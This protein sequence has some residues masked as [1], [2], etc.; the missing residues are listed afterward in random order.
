MRG[1]AL[2]LGAAFLG[3]TILAA[4]PGPVL[5]LAAGDFAPN[6]ASPAAPSWF[7]ATPTWE[8]PRGSRYLVAIMRGPLGGKER[9]QLEATGVSILGYVPVHG[10]QLRVPPVSEAAARRLPFVAW[11]GPLPPHLKLAP[12]LSASSPAAAADARVRIILAAGEPSARVTALLGTMPS[13]ATPSGKDGAYRVVATIPGKSLATTLS[14]IASLPEVEAIEPARRF[15]PMNQDAVW[16]HQ[17]FVGPSPQTTPI[18]ARGIF[19]CGQIAAIADT[20]QDYDLCFFRDT[21]NGAPP[22]ASCGAAPCP[23]AATASRR[24]DLLYYNWSGGPTGEEDTCPATTTGSSGHGTHISGSLAG[25]TSPYADCAGFTT[26]NRNGGDGVAPGAK[27]VFQE[28]GDSYEYLNDLGGTLWNLADVAFQN[29][30]RVHSN[31][32]GGACYDQLGNCVPGCTMPYDSYARDADLA[33]WSH[34]DLL[35]VTAAGNGGAFCPPPVS[36]GTPATAKSVLTVGAVEHGAAANTPSWFTSVGPV[37]DGRLGVTVA[38]QGESTVSAAS[39]MNLGSNNC[40]TCS[41]DGTSMSAPTAAG[42]AELVREYYTAGFAFQGTRDPAHGFSPSGALLKA[43]LID[44]AVALGAPAPGPDFDSGYGRIQLDRTLAFAGSA[45]QLRVDDHREGLSTGSVAAHAYDVAA[46]TPF[47]VTLAW[48]DYPAALNAAVARVNELKLEVTDPT[49]AVWFQTI[50]AGTGLPTQTSS[51]ANPHDTRNVVERLV[52]DSPA[53]GRW[54]VRVRGIDVPFGP[55]PF[56]LV[57]RGALADCPAPA[58]PAA[59]TLGTPADH[60]VSVTW[61]AVGGAAAYNVY[62]A[63]GGCPGSSFVFLGTTASTSFLDTTVSGGV[64]YG[65]AVAA[66]SDSAAACESPRSACA[67]VVP[68]GDCFVPPSFAGVKTASSTG[69]STCAVQL[70]WDP[71]AAACSGDLRYNVYRDTSGSFTPGPSNRIARCLAGTSFTDSAGLTFNTAHWYIVRAED[72]AGGHSGPCRGGNEDGN[73]VRLQAAADGPSA[74]G[75]WSDDAGDTGVAKL[76]TELP[77]ASVATGGHAAPRAYQATSFDGAC[78]NLATPALTL[79]DPGQGPSLSFWTKHDLE[80]DPIGEILGTEGSV[81][82]AEIATGPSFSNWTRL[83]LTPNYPENVEFPFND[84]P[85]TQLTTRYFT[86]NHLTYTFYNAALTNWA[87]GDVKIRFHLSGDHI[88]SGGHWWVDDIA[89]TKAVVPG[90]CQTAAAGPPPIPDGGFVPGNPMRASRSGANI[91]VTWD[92]AQ[93]PAS[94][95]TVYRGAIGSYGAFT[96]ASCNL[97]STGSATVAMPNNSWFLVVATD[98]ATTDG[99]YARGVN[100]G[101]LVYAGAPSVCPGTTSHVVSNACP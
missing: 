75:T 41:L 98:G 81:G 2:L 43:T 82:Q 99:S 53:P 34:P 21:V 37:E 40:A 96:S 23:A 70:A 10:Y 66:A 91:A 87:G 1:A 44:G 14:A 100:G 62:R 29:G 39:D 89:V 83:P 77:W 26:P 25:D 79:A 47:R 90:S 50:D 65:Y 12:E 59:P 27:L 24:K 42:T 15:R 11:L 78:V 94:F 74:V 38:A 3:A 71:G 84:C 73:L 58:S 95:V 13:L 8:S 55:Q 4:E 52:F 19:G 64:T 16:V 6:A 36:I 48:S 57:V 60:Q 67:S 51:A 33:M 46:G 88:Y 92:V 22:V 68:T 9:E 5:H 17:S 76:S 85:T 32:W 86:G 49:G 80:Y 72:A 69:Q 97:P 35:I 63:F 7:H 61:P 54:I 93:C 20:A 28:M 45:F 56:A 30:A 18:F 101:E 31:S